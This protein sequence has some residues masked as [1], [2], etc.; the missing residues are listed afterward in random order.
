LR[1]TT[2]R[3][4]NA[5]A[6]GLVSGYVVDSYVLDWM[7]IADIGFY[8]RAM[9][10]ALRTANTNFEIELIHGLSAHHSLTSR[11]TRRGLTSSQLDV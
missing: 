1:H 6:E 5:R 11:H 10:I 9:K 2:A 4:H 7:L 8:W 3:S